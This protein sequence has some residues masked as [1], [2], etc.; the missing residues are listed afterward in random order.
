MKEGA[1]MPL[2]LGDIQQ[3]VNYGKVQNNCRLAHDIS[4][5]VSSAV[6]K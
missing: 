4:G 1:F 2:K 3:M 6:C 5:S